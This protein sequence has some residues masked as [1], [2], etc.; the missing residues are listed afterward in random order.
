MGMVGSEERQVAPTEFGRSTARPPGDGPYGPGTMASVRT[1]QD[2]ADHGLR[3]RLRVSVV[4]L[5]PVG[6][7]DRRLS[8]AYL[9]GGRDRRVLSQARVHSGHP[10]GLERATTERRSDQSAAETIRA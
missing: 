1:P 5:I 6:V 4:S 8:E 3:D 9:S 2:H 7:A 10:Q